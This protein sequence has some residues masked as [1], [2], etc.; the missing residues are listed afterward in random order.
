MITSTLT[1][2][3]IEFNFSYRRMTM[4]PIVEFHFHSHIIIVFL[5][6]CSS[7]SHNTNFLMRICCRNLIRFTK[8]SSISFAII[9]FDDVYFITIYELWKRF[10]LLKLIQVSNEF[11]YMVIPWL[12]HLVSPA[13]WFSRMFGLVVSTDVYGLRYKWWLHRFRRIIVWAITHKIWYH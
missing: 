10:I 11:S 5:T 1:A 3:L 8:A 6:N 4:I 7:H 13:L 2:I 9:S 12:F